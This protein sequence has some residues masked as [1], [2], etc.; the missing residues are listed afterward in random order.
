MRPRGRFLLRTAVSP[1]ALLLCAAV[2]PGQSAAVLGK[3]NAKFLEGLWQAGYVDY[4]D[5]I[6]QLV[7]ASNLPEDEKKAVDVLH[8]KLKIAIF[9][10]QGNAKERHALIIKGLDDKV[11]QLAAAAP[12]SEACVD[13]LSEVI[14][15]YRLLADVVVELLAQEKDPAAQVEIRKQAV[16][17]FA[18]AVADLKERKKSY[19]S[20]RDEEKPGT[21]VPLLVAFYGIGKILYYQSLIHPAET[22]AA[23]HLVEES[24][25]ALEDFDLEFGDTFAG[26]E[27]KLI[28]ALC[29]KRIGD[30]EAALELCDE[31]IALRERFDH[32]KKTGIY[33]V[34]SNAADVIAAAVLQKSM[35]LK[36]AGDQAKIVD[37]AKDFFATIPQAL[38]AQ[39]GK[40]VL[41]AQGE[42]Y[43]HLGDNTSATAVAQKLLEIDP[44]GR[45]GYRGQELLSQIVTGGGGNVGSG[46]T[47]QIAE[48]LAGQGEFERALLMCRQ[49]MLS[50]KA[51]EEEKFAA[52]AM[53]ITGAI[54]ATRGWFHEAAVAN[55]AV[56]KRFPKSEFAPDALWRAIQCYIEL[57]ETDRLGVFKKHIED[58]SKQLVR[59][60]PTDPHVGQLQLL[61]G[62]Q[63]ERG[64]K[65]L[66][67]AQVF[68]RIKS[69]SVVYL[70]ARY[71]AAN[72]YHRHARKLEG[73]QP[74]EAEQFTA[75]AQ[76]GFESVL[77]DAESAKLTVVD[78][79]AK[80]RIEQVEFGARI[81]LA[82]LFL[83]AKKANPAEAEK[84]LK[85]ITLKDDDKQAPT[86]WAL[87]IRIKQEQ[88]NL[89]DAA[90]EM[91][92]ALA[93]A[94][95]SR[96]LFA[97]CRSLAQA[98]DTRAVERSKQKERRSA[99]ED[100][101]KATSYYLRS[102]TG[103]T[104]AELAQI[105]E[106]LR[107]I[108]LVVNEVGENV[109]GWF[110]LQNF[111]P[112]DT[113]AW[114]G[115]LDI[116]RRLEDADA[117]TYKTRV[118]RASILGYLGKWEECE[119]ELT[120]VFKENDI[121][122]GDRLDAA[123]LRNKPELLNAYLE[124][125]FAAQMPTGG[126]DKSRRVF[127]SERFGRVWRS[128][129]SGSKQWW[130]SYYGQIQ[131][132]FDRGLY[133]EAD[134]SLGSLERTNPEFDG[135]KY[136]LKLRFS[137]LKTQIKAK[138]P[139][140][141]G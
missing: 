11:A 22:L 76:G 14:D 62:R 120:K 110:E 17:R 90:A 79:K 18:S 24:L 93:K 64:G 138:L 67:A 32:E 54:Y 70:D 31:A 9:A 66:E 121:R 140:K 127:A 27:A 86:I 23:K 119:A 2:L 95:D 113:T 89:D 47:L 5:T 114:Q 85:P 88:G 80:G 55:D 98:L 50:A 41:A 59:D 58:R 43:L 106:R 118:G 25:A 42:A 48:S 69:D 12:G 71:Y 10:Q 7:A 45:W 6:G 75:K 99:N 139:R 19:A 77:K 49:T 87:R 51:P 102:A 128:V 135:D 133:P 68:E 115:A 83:S 78:P 65:S 74:A 73:S 96:D 60:Y 52:E 108:G 8:T 112:R 82:N 131:T 130:Y 30:M 132:A 13:M 1:L 56:V 117:T 92:A 94:G 123:S 81:A 116:Y 104:N 126:E 97:T 129:P 63:L 109:E 125:A 33:Q 107:I 37:A 72:A 35:F 105:A 21:E 103:A 141:G 20:L 34:D 44:K 122:S 26:F 84:I 40:A 15:Q 57:H 38:D 29:Q 28:M 136:G 16:E 124:W 39:L 91:Q 61:E 3:R 134:V 53:F 46:K 36:D 4:A 101:A 111:K 137:L 100:W